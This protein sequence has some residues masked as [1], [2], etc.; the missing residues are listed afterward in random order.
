MQPLK[1]DVDQILMGDDLSTNYQ[2]MPGDRLVAPTASRESV[3]SGRARAGSFGSDRPGTT[4]GPAESHRAEADGRPV[5]ARN[6]RRPDGNGT[7][8]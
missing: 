4:R 6:D 7:T 3:S 8:N 1:I 5:A 2:L